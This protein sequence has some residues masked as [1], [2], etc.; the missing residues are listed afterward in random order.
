MLL[1]RRRGPAIDLVLDRLRQDRSQFV[2]TT[3]RGG[4][5]GIFW[6]TRNQ[7]RI[8]AGRLPARAR[9]EVRYPEI[10]IVVAETRPL[11]EEWTFRFLGAAKA[12]DGSG[13]A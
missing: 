1:C 5:E 13:S 12:E 3:M 9:V 10:R 4:L 7:A 6:Q 11:A 2:V 8:R